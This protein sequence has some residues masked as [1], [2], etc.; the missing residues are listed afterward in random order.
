MGGYESSYHINRFGQRI[1]MQA[2]VQHDRFARED[3]RLLKEFGISSARDAIRW[4][5][6][7]RGGAY[8]FSSFAPMLQAARDEGVQIIWDL[9][10][11]GWPD[12]VDQP[13]AAFDDRYA[14]YSR[15]VARFIADSGEEIP[16]YTPVNEISYLAFAIGCKVI[17]P[18]VS[19]RDDEVK[20]QFVRAAIAAVDA[21][22]DVDPRARLVLGD[23]I[24]HVIA[25]KDRPDL[26]EIAATYREVQFQAWD[27]ISGRLHPDLGGSPKYLDIIGLNYYHANQFEFPSQR[28]RWEDEPRDPR[29]LPLSTL[30]EEVYVRYKKPL[31][32]GETSHFGAGRAKWIAEVA[33]EVRQARLSGV[34][35]EGICLYPIVDRPDWENYE[36][37]HNCGLWD[38]QRNGDGSLQRL[39]NAEYAAE[40]RRVQAIVP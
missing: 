7:D 5:L 11:Y 6:V 38:M 35:I 32:V 4:H 23:P 40:L 16:F 26:R 21:V 8:D 25:P 15:A 14:R 1:D 37:W 20:R 34:P 31:F 13:S 3:Y 19:G 29:M 30:L 12:D 33:A 17:Y 2:V 9:C 39:V 27:M 22:R 28:L 18:F 10:H 24:V 36:H